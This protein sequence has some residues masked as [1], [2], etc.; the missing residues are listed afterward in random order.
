MFVAR[1]LTCVPCAVCVAGGPDLLL[2]AVRLLLH[3]GRLGAQEA[4]AAAAAQLGLVTAP[5]DA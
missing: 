3:R 2:G 1:R 4:A 5:S